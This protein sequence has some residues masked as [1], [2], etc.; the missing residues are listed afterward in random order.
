MLSIDEIIYLFFIF[1]NNFLQ[2]PRGRKA[3][4]VW[5]F[6]LMKVFFVHGPILIFFQER[7][8]SVLRRQEGAA[9][10]ALQAVRGLPGRRAPVRAPPGG[11]RALQ[12]QPV[13]GRHLHLV[14]SHLI[15]VLHTRRSGVRTFKHFFYV[16]Q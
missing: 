7:L 16:V 13:G 9:G 4:Q 2:S 15:L 8:H 12:S 14:G 6:F 11:G 5:F 10:G 3:R 1:S